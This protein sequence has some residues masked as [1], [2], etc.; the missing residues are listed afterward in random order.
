VKR[1]DGRNCISLRAEPLFGSS[2]DDRVP[3]QRGKEQARLA[4]VE[5]PTL[6]YR[7]RGRFKLIQGTVVT[8]VETPPYDFDRPSVKRWSVVVVIDRR[9]F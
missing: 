9:A 8:G 3:Y 2:V 6:G 4:F 5:Y 1:N 7:F